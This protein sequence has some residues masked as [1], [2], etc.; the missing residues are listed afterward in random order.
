MLKFLVGALLVANLGL[1]VVQ[2]GQPAGHEPA[3]MNNQLN[4]DRIRLLPA[5]A[6]SVPAP[7]AAA[8][9]PAP[10]PAETVASAA[11]NACIE[12]LSFTAAEATRRMNDPF[13]A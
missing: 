10:A 5:S 13:P 6:A 3:R 11:P 2:R 4:P 1:F 7:A 8:P 9:E 12:L